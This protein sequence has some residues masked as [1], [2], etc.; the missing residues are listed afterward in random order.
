[1]ELEARKSNLNPRSSEFEELL[2]HLLLDAYVFDARYRERKAKNTFVVPSIIEWDTDERAER[3]AWRDEGGKRD[4]QRYTLAS[5]AH[6][7][8]RHVKALQSHETI[9]Q[10]AGYALLDSPQEATD[11]LLAEFEAQDKSMPTL[12]KMDETAAILGAA[13]DLI[14]L[15]QNGTID[16]PAM[17]N[18]A[19]TADFALDY[20]GADFDRSIKP[21]ASRVR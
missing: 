14:D 11:A 15:F 20:V 8:L 21:S 4:A 13:A 18:L 3:L 7:R 5:I 6:L 2:Y 12:L 16:L 9:E 17:D 10:D 1:M 19:D